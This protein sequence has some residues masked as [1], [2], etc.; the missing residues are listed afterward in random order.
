MSL[1]REPAA[2]TGPQLALAGAAEADGASRPTHRSYDHRPMVRCPPHDA[3]STHG[4][5]TP[6]C[7]PHVEE[8][9]VL[10]I[11]DAGRRGWLALSVL[12]AGTA[13]A[14]L[15]LLPTTSS[16]AATST[17]CERGDFTVTA[18]GGKAL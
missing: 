11:T 8:N 5:G 10:H 18:P 3:V 17:G 4:T 9:F 14:A 13:L 15:P 7:R 1:N 16:F 2:L 12:T 6:R